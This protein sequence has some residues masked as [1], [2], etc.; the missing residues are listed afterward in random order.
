VTVL[1]FANGDPE[2]TDWVRQQLAR[3]TAV[4]AADGGADYVLAAGGIPDVVIGDLDSLADSKRAA[5]EAAGVAFIQ[6]PTAKDETDLELALLY[7]VG[8]SDEPV[9]VVAGLG[10]RLDQLLANILLLLHPALQQR[11]IHFVTPYQTIWLIDGET[12]VR[13]E[14]GDTVSL[15][16]LGGDVHVRTTTGLAWP[17]HDEILTVGPARGVSNEMT[18]DRASITVASGDL[19][20]VHTTREW[21]R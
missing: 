13:G 21:E 19:L 10:G 11:S 8:T 12:E 14:P 3:A 7:A 18:G 16:P 1:V 9:D 2:S 20:C 5:L 4:I 17:L 6:H 15:I